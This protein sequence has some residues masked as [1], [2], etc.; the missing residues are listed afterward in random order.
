MCEFKI[1]N[2]IVAHRKGTSWFTDGFMY[3][4]VKEIEF[5]LLL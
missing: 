1:N 4:L 2:T 5:S 3:S